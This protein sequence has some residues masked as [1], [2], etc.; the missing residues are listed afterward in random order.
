VILELED[1]KLKNI[2]NGEDIKDQSFSKAPKIV[3]QATSQ[4]MHAQAAKSAVGDD[5]DL[6][7]ETSR[8]LVSHDNDHNL[9]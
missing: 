4:P 1:L 6:N 3:I 7:G 9:K 8:D 5:D 2:P